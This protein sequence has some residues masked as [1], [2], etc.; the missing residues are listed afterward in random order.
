MS[1]KE[2]ELADKKFAVPYPLLL[3]FRLGF[4]IAANA[5]EH[6]LEHVKDSDLRKE[7]ETAISMSR[8]FAAMIT[9]GTGELP[10]EVDKLHARIMNAM[11]PDASAED[12]EPK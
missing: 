9:R 6:A 3:T 8:E 10:T 7:L 1:G 5:A 4:N 12:K 11:K 2:K